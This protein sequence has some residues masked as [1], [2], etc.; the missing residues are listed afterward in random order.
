M[1]LCP[2][3]PAGTKLPHETKK[4][5]GIMPACFSSLLNELWMYGN[6]GRIRHTEC[7]SVGNRSEVL[8]TGCQTAEG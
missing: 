1:Q 5:A 7:A 6:D 3:T 8:D 4:Q 2:G